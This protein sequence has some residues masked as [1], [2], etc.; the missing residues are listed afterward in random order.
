[1]HRTCFLS[2]TA[3]IGRREKRPDCKR[4]IN[5]LRPRSKI[6][7][8]HKGSWGTE[9]D[10]PLA[11]RLCEDGNLNVALETEQGSPQERTKTTEPSR[12]FPEVTLY[13][14]EQLLGYESLDD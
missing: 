8:W 5:T 6:G 4:G 2:F 10:T 12:N 1:M 11:T 9:K 7:R 14:Q 13:A 3:G